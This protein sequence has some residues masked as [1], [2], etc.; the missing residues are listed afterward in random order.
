MPE[1]IF[2]S[3]SVF[4]PYNFDKFDKPNNENETISQNLYHVSGWE[5]IK[6]LKP[7]DALTLKPG[8]HNAQGE[9]VYFSEDIPR[10]SA[11][12]NLTQNQKSPSAIIEIIATNIEGWYRSKPELVKKYNKPRTWHSDGKEMRL[13]VLTRNKLAIDGIEVPILHCAYRW[14][15]DDE[16]KHK[17]VDAN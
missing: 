3:D 11:A 2:D 1:K 9:G 10:V 13:V 17:D 7:G 16:E 6:D 12:D 15:S 14:I 5:E 4:Q 8:E